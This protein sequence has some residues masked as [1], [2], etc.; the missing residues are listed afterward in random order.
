MA[1]RRTAKSGTIL[2]HRASFQASPAYPLRTI[3]PSNKARR[4]GRSR[5]E[6]WTTWRKNRAKWRNN[7]P[8]L[9]AVRAI[10][11]ALLGHIEH[12][13]ILH[14]PLPNIT[15][16]H[17]D[18]CLWPISFSISASTL[19]AFLASSAALAR[20][21]SPRCFACSASESMTISF[22]SFGR[23][24]ANTPGVSRLT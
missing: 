5:N 13:G 1:R 15:L 9:V 20:W 10:M 21:S 14:S 19:K 4:S 24:F 7:F 16:A 8:R 18:Y 17:V 6:N 2:F 22:R 3:G 12:K 23:I 11:V